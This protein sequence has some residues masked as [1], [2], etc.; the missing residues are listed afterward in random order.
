MSG[1]KYS[2]YTVERLGFVYYRYIKTLKAEIA[3][4]ENQLKGYY[5]SLLYNQDSPEL[6]VYRKEVRELIDA[7]KAELLLIEA[8]LDTL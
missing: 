5:N 7:L 8:K 2:K 6:E 1:E 3:M 4:Q